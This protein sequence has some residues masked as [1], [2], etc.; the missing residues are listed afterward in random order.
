MSLLK[1]LRSLKKRYIKS[2]DKMVFSKEADYYYINVDNMS[3]DK[4]ACIGDFDYLLKEL[5][6]MEK[7]YNKAVKKY[8]K[9]HSK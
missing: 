9:D 6:D 8:K 5:E 4:Q 3:Y 7:A 1:S 2:M